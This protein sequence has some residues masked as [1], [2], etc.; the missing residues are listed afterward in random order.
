[1]SAKKTGSTITTTVVTRQG[2]L[3]ISSFAARAGSLRHRHPRGGLQI[4]RPDGSRYCIRQATS[5]DIA[6]TKVTDVHELGA[7][8]TNAEW[9]K[10][11]AGRGAGCV[12]CHSI[13]RIVNST[14][15]A[16]EFVDIIQRMAL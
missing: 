9:M 15:T 14:H 11:H 1:V 7:Q 12:N 6:L 4:E 2:T 5:T 8:L 10:Q 3:R 13:Q 16:E